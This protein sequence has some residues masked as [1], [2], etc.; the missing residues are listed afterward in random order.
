[1]LNQ[2]ARTNQEKATSGSDYFSNTESIPVIIPDD[3]GAD[4][5]AQDPRQHSQELRGYPRWR[6][7]QGH[8]PST[9]KPSFNPAVLA[10]LMDPNFVASLLT[11]PSS[12]I[13]DFQSAPLVQSSLASHISHKVKQAILRGEYVKFVT[14]L[15]ENSS[16]TNSELPGMSI[17][18]DGK[19]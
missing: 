12:S 5:A 15:P 19:Q 3:T 8:S 18:F 9:A 7:Y 11:Q 6:P 13:N 2:R 1:M 16:V 14:L 17:S 4:W 10:T